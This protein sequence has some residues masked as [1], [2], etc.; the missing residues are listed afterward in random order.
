MQQK[1]VDLS[2][3][4]TLQRYGAVLCVAAAAGCSGTADAEDTGARD[5]G[6]PDGTNGVPGQNDPDS[7]A[8]APALTASSDACF[9][10]RTIDGVSAYG[11]WS[12]DPAARLLTR[13]A[14]DEQGKPATAV[15]AVGDIDYWKLDAAGRIVMKAYTV[16][17]GTVF[18]I[19]TTRDEHGNTVSSRSSYHV[20]FDVNAAYDTS[21]F[22]AGIP[23]HW[24]QYSN[25]YDDQGLLTRQIPILDDPATSA[26]EHVEDEALAM[27]FEHDPQ[28]RCSS[29]TQYT[30]QVDEFEYDDQGKLERRAVTAAF[31][32][33]FDG[34]FDSTITY[35]RDDRGRLTSVM[36]T[37]EGSDAP[38]ARLEL[39]YQSDGRLVE[40][41][42]LDPSL[43]AAGD[44]FSHTVWSPGC[45]DILQLMTLEPG[46]EC[47]TE[48]LSVGG[49]W[50][51]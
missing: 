32:T 30:N 27:R 44:G 17:L 4:R 35:V 22:G 28:G 37:Y 21:R 33:G 11:L 18:R 26:L 43:G 13:L 12:Y 6:S 16:G 41:R 48:S 9:D 50:Q 7:S 34:R 45:A 38:I 10:E 39:T 14:V 3:R 20:P 51:P 40:E 15:N 24:F 1:H 5:D 19:N 36:E 42:Q 8:A 46:L 31:R 29:I 23:Y 49:F 47:H 25:E 2:I